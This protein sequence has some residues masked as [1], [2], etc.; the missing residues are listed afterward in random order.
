[1]D[2]VLWISVLGGSGPVKNL[3]SV[4]RSKRWNFELKKKK[5]SWETLNGGGWKRAD[6]EKSPRH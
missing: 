4:C 2:R 6:A 5:K 1:M 3:K